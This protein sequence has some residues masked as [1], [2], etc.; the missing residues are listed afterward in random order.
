MCYS[1]SPQQLSAGKVKIRVLKD[2]PLTGESFTATTSAFNCALHAPGRQQLWVLGYTCLCW[3]SFDSPRGD[4][5]SGAATDQ[6]P[7]NGWRFCVL[8]PVTSVR[9]IPGI[10]GPAA[11]V[12]LFKIDLCNQWPTWAEL[13]MCWTCLRDQITPGT[14]MFKNEPSKLFMDGLKCCIKKKRKKGADNSNLLYKHDHL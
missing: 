6:S 8:L 3:N 1:P 14:G 4:C 10:T 12:L 9:W 7:G 11:G 2:E 13:L 5:H